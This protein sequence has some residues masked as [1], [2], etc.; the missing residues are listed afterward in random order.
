MNIL[1]YTPSR[2]EPGRA[3]A[4]KD[5]IVA[6]GVGDPIDTAASPAELEEKI[7]A[8]E[9]L[10][11]FRLPAASRPLAAKLR[12]IQCL[13]AGVDGILAGGGLPDGVRLT[14]VIGPFG[15]VMSEYV[16]AELLY[17]EKTIARLRDQQAQ[18]VWDPFDAGTLR[19]KKIGLAGLGAIGTEVARKALAFDMEVTGLSRTGA[20]VPGV[21]RVFTNDAWEDFVKD[22]DYLV[23]ILP[24]TPHTHHLVG[25][26]VLAAMKEGAVLVNVG[27]GA[28]VDETA[29]VAA[30]RSG[31]LGGAILD[32]FE[33]EP[34]PPESPLWTLPNVVVTP[35]LSGPTTIDDAARAF[36]KNLAHLNAGE[37]LEAEV[38]LSRGY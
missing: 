33:K 18:K 7:P 9:A 3:A 24:H 35:H 21:S 6:L 4:L 11:C 34:L 1:L 30:L 10:L 31:K 29:L 12:W 27:R 38:D 26:R 23:L 8:A 15:P 28:V 20:P 32:V 25:T 17:R 5:A 19:Q 13:G 37:P 22:L 16:F 2:T 36:A 14:R